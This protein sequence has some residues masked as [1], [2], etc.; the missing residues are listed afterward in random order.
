MSLDTSA[1]RRQFPA[2]QQQIN[3]HPL[4][5]LDSAATAQVPMAVLEAM[6]ECE[7][8]DRGNP[9]R[10][11]HV[12][13]ERAT[14]KFESARKTVAEFIGAATHE[15][16][17]TR[18]ATES[19][20][21]VAKSWGKQNVKKGDVVALTL[22][23]HHSAIV[24]WLQHKEDIGIE[25]A[26]VGID[27][28]GMP[29]MEELEE[30]LKAGKTK[31]VC[32]TGQSNVLGVRP[33]LKD[34]IKTAHASGALVTVDATQLIAHHP[35]DVADLDCDFLVFSGHKLYG[36][37]GIGVLYGKRKLL[38]A[39][40]PFLGGGGMIGN[41]TKTGFTAADIPQ[42]FEAGTPPLAQA[43]G[44]AA[45]IDWISQYPWKDI[46]AHETK[47]IR[48]AVTALADIPDLKFLPNF[49]RDKVPQAGALLSGCISFIIRGSH[50]HDLTDVL[51]NRGIC[52]RAG[53]HCCQPLHDHLNIPAS[54]RVSVG[55]Y[56]TEDE[57]TLLVRAI[58]EA[59]KTLA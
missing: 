41:V 22:L 37:T 51:G 57:V 53:H 52:L 4:V 26:W 6:S 8:H 16:I 36:P 28:T 38:E 10:G 45:T 56:N 59:L 54:T 25:I 18:N 14:E 31:M 1:I 40:P 17:F 19:L 58:D 13:A 33:P 27:E 32:I 9:H 12:L 43:V 7:R 42:K 39:M 46:E 3:G 11:M 23:E 47:L 48:A 24:P 15:I 44:L 20:N 21:I 2:L 5:Y 29:R 50:P 55:I 49:A 34:I 35:V 30:L